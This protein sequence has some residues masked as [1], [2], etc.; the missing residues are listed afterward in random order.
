MV[1]GRTRASTR[2]QVEQGLLLAAIFVV[3]ALFRLGELNAIRLTYDNSYT[4]YDALRGLSG[5]GPRATM[6]LL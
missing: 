4:I 6:M 1:I 2:A 5:A 3:G